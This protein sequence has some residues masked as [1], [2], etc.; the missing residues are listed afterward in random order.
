[1]GFAWTG[2]NGVPIANGSGRVGSNVF[3]GLV[4]VVMGEMRAESRRLVASFALAKGSH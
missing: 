3:C 2:K 1:V 4:R